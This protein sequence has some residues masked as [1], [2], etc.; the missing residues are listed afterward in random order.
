MSYTVKKLM[1]GVAISAAV[2][3]FTVTPVAVAAPEEC[4]SSDTVT[5][6]EQPGSA[7]VAAVPAQENQPD[8][9][10]GAQNGPYGP[11]GARPPVGN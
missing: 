10:S 4:Q 8:G 2:V 3:A 9:D 5:V 11:A 6:C 1:T 7:A